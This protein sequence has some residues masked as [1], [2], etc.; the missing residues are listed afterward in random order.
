[1]YSLGL[2]FF[3]PVSAENVAKQWQVS[4]EE[5]DQLAVKSQ[6]KAEHAQKSGYFDKE[7]VPVPVASRKS[8]CV[9]LDC[10]GNW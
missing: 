7:I 2:L 8:M 3:F 10:I 1:M 5:Q 6:Q 4:R 9:L